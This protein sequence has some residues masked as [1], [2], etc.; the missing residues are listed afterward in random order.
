MIEPR[1]LRF[2]PESAYRGTRPN[3]Y[4]TFVGMGTRHQLGQDMLVGNQHNA[5]ASFEEE[6][7]QIRQDLDEALR[8]AKEYFQSKK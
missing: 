7:R 3:A 2:G 1:F 5:L 4:I 8:E 6:V